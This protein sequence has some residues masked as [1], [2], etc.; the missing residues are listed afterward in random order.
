MEKNYLVL[1]FSSLILAFV[2]IP[3]LLYFLGNFY[4]KGILMETLSVITILGF[5][6]LLSQ[7]FTSR[8]NE[9]LIKKIKMKNVL[10]VHK[11]I[12]YLFISLLVFH[13]FFIIVPKFFDNTVAPKNALVK[14]LTTFNTSGIIFGLL[15]YIT[16]L[17]LIVTSY[18]RS[19]L[20]FKYKTWRTL[21]GYLTL[22]FIV[23]ATWHVI[24][25]GKHSNNSFAVYYF[26]AATVGIFYLLKTYILEWEKK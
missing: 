17:I 22:F 10:K 13:P 15:A 4:S 6:L 5:T 14:L 7:F 16:M 11:F 3:L 23:S 2:A 9:S 26:L 8:L 25:S 21:H 18:F 12:G 20:P 19:K 24:Y 1:K